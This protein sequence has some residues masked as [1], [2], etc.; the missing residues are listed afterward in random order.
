ML[1][2]VVFSHQHKTGC[3]EGGT[4]RRWWRQRGSIQKEPA[5]R[6]LERGK[7]GILWDFRFFELQFLLVWRTLWQVVAILLSQAGTTQKRRQTGG[8]KRADMQKKESTENMY[9]KG[10]IGVFNLWSHNEQI[11]A[12]WK[13]S[14]VSV[15]QDTRCV[16]KRQEGRELTELY[17]QLQ[18][19]ARHIKNIKKREFETSVLQFRPHWIAGL[20][21]KVTEKVKRKQHLWSN[22]CQRTWEKT[23]RK[24]EEKEP[25]SSH[26]VRL[27]RKKI[28]D[29]R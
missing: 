14:S 22:L 27:R 3:I 2:L 6:G 15:K 18:V 26:C 8:K 19:Q 4:V 12:I 28:Q 21:R 5:K 23:K 1:F 20:I 29:L 9:W 11:F 25:G 7:D 13:L 16:Q 17:V 10:N 24:K